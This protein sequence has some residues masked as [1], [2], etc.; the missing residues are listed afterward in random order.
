MNT[1]KGREGL[2]TIEE[3]K[4]EAMSTG[5]LTYW[6]TNSRKRPH[7]MNVLRQKQHISSISKNVWNS[8]FDFWP[9][10]S[11]FNIK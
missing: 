6:L 1:T 4:C 7:L 2:G 9:F 8:R 11:I 5:K 3:H 10:F